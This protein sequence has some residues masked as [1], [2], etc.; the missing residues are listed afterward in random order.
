MQIDP[1]QTFERLLGKIG[2]PAALR[3]I[4]QNRFY[5]GFVDSLPGVLEYMGV[6]ALAE[7]ADDPE[8]DLVVLD[9]PP[10]AR[11][12]DFLDA[13]RR[14]VELLRNDALR[15]FLDDQ[16]LLGR[17]LSGSARG[18]A[19]LLRLADRALGLG[20]LGDLADFFRAFD[21]L[22]AGF[23]ERSLS[24][25]A[26]LSGARFAVVSAPDA[27]PMRTAAGLALSLSARGASPSLLLN[28]VPD[29]GIGPAGLPAGLSRL[30]LRSFREDSGSSEDL[31]GRLASAWSE[32]SPRPRTIAP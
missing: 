26:R 27:S 3:R 5:E 23:E 28:R 9:T 14:M 24:V 12:L 7:H 10:A 13:P 22:Y 11:G 18:A 2:T 30:P 1:R 20:F 31:P 8:L 21:G 25:A 16:S 6:E 17:A 32:R 15:W 19:V 4:H 29:I